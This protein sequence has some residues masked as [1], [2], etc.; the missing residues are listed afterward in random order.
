MYVHFPYMYANLSWQNYMRMIVSGAIL[1]VVPSCIDSEVI[2]RESDI[3]AI[4][5]K[6]WSK[7]F[8]FSCSSLFLAS[9]I[10]SVAVLLTRWKRST[11]QLCPPPSALVSTWSSSLHRLPSWS[12]RNHGS[13][14]Q[15]YPWILEDFQ[16]SRQILHSPEFLRAEA[17]R[18]P[19]PLAPWPLVSHSMGIQPS[20]EE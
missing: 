16:C 10:I 8:R 9:K 17:P 15:P 11:H 19:G 4:N 20:L 2:W 1:Y 5:S 6:L 13:Q 14:P 7:V 12:S 3:W 18:I